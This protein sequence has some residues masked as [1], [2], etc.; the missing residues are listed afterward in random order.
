MRNP[1]KEKGDSKAFF[2]FTVING[3][4]NVFWL[5]AYLICL[6]LRAQAFNTA[7]TNMMLSGQNSYTVEVTSPFFAILKFM[8]YLLPVV[9]VVWTVLMTVTDSKNKQLCDKW[10]IG[11][12]FGTELVSAILITADITMLHMVF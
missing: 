4:L 10:L 6:A 3:V 2:A 9:I 11:T 7:Q 1:L 5:A 12:V 8:A